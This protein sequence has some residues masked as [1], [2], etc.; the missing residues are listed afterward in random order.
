MKY[1]FTVQPNISANTQHK[2]SRQR[3]VRR[4]DFHY[5]R[6]LTAQVA[7]FEYLHT[8]V[9]EKE[10]FLMKDLRTYHLQKE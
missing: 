4:D 6:L 8:H 1:Y 5:P 7:W 3:S 9:M 10:K 2:I